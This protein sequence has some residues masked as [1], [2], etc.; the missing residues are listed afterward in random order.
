MA[1]VSALAVYPHIYPKLGYDPI[2]DLVPVAGF[3]TSPL[4]V[5]VP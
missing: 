5:V 2:K 1:P 4:V 3:A